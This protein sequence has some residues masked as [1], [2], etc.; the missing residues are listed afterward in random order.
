MPRPVSLLVAGALVLG[1]GAALAALGVGYAVSGLLGHP[2]DRLGT[3]LAG[4]LA[5]LCG[6]VLV[7]AGRALRAG[8]SWPWSPTVLAQLLTAV[9]AVGLLQGGV[10]QVGVPLLLLAAGVLYLLAT[11]E[12]R[13]VYRSQA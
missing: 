7:A 10:W 3:V 12:A 9:V 4:L 2:E 5:L 13:A 6:A 11:P 8:S 1:E